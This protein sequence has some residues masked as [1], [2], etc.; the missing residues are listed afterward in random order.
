MN[1]YLPQ[2]SLL[3]PPTHTHTQYNCSV[4]V[5]VEIEVLGLRFHCNCEGEEVFHNSMYSVLLFVHLFVK[6]FIVVVFCF[7]CFL[8]GEHILRLATLGW[9]VA[10]LKHYCPL[11]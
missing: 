1:D 6:K 2:P 9:L 8:L 5:G 7:R 4:A 10:I 11:F 3:P